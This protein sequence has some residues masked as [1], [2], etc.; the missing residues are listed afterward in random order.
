MDGVTQLRAAIAALPP[1]TLVALPREA[2]LE[3][4]GG[5]VRANE[6]VERPVKRS[7]EVSVQ[8]PVDLTVAELAQRFR[9]SPS[10]VR[11][12][13]GSGQLE[14]Y[15]LFG[16]E[17]RVTPAAV[18]AFQESQ[19]QGQAHRPGSDRRGPS[20]ADWRKVQ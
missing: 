6:P 1:G 7:V 15:K 4:L 14:G 8:V 19:R 20:L 12:W 9:R 10:T 16:R 13:L 3:V 11:Q 18:A 2:L 17:W 5:T